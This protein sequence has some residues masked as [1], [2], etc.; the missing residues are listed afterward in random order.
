MALLLTLSAFHAHAQY[1]NGSLVGTIK[2]PTG[3][4]IANATVT[5]TNEATAIATTV[6]T[7][8]AG[9]YEVP[10]LKVGAY[11]I[12]ATAQGFSSTRATNITVSVGGRPAS[13]LASRWAPETATVEVTRR[14]T[15]D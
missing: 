1:D 11:D 2:D 3:A 7:N 10:T 6:K 4:P 12:S 8:S 9:D 5:I 15:P 14:S 13:I